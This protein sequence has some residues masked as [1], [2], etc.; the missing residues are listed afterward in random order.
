MRAVPLSVDT[1]ISHWDC[2]CVSVQV[3]KW[4]D[5]CLPLACSPGG[6]FRVVAE[7]SVDNFSRLGVAFMEDR[8]WLDNGFVPEKIVCEYV[9]MTD[10]CRCLCFPFL[11]G[12]ACWDWA[13]RKM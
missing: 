6:P 4:S 13:L 12:S 8:L 10:R 5:Y 11:P 7:A 2:A 3:L 1:A 9:S